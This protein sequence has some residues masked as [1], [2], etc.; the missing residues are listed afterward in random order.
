MKNRLSLFK[1]KKA[2]QPIKRKDGSIVEH[3]GKVIS[4]PE[5]RGV[6]NMNIKN[7]A[8]GEY[9]AMDYEVGV[10]KATAKSGLVYYTG[11]IKPSFKGD[12]Q[13]IKPVDNHNVA[14]GNGYQPDSIIDDEVP[15]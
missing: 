12:K 7:P 6:I 10:Y 14:K 13:Q 8:T 15:F 4:E 3:N 1:N 5:Y 11:T 2:G 9:E